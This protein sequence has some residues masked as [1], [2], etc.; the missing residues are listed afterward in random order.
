MADSGYSVHTSVTVPPDDRDGLDRLARHL[1]LLPAN[2]NRLRAD[3]D[4]G[5]LTHAGHRHL[6]GRDSVNE[7]ERDPLD[8]LAGVV[9]HIPDSRP[10]CLQ[11]D[12]LVEG[13]YWVRSSD[14][15]LATGNPSVSAAS[16]RRWS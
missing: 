5:S 9:M 15:R 13:D 6:L 7:A 2:L 10:E 4:A 8:V 3:E 16:R 14:S 11:S 1:L 12:P